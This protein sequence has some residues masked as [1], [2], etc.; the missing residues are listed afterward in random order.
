MVA[1]DFDALPL[2]ARMLVDHL[3]ARAEAA[4]PALIAQ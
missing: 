3:Q 4:E 1:R 2:T